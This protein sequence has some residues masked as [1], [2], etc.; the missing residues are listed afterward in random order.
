MRKPKILFYGNCQIGAISKIFDTHPILKEKFTVLNAGDYN[1]V[2]QDPYPAVANFLLNTEGKNDPR[3]IEKIF[4]D[5]DIVVFQALNNNRV[6]EYCLTKNIIPDFDGLS[7]CIPSFWYGGY[8]GA[9]Y[10][11]PMLDLFYYFNKLGLSN[12]EALNSL[13]NEPILITEKLFVY[14]HDFSIEGLKSRS[15]EQAGN[16]NF[17][18]ILDWLQNTYKNRLLCYNHSHPTPV[19]FNFIVNKILNKIDPS[20]EDMNLSKFN[21]VHAGPDGYFLP[22][23]FRFF[24]DLFPD[25]E[26]LSKLEISIYD[27]WR[28]YNSQQ[29]EIFVNEGMKYVKENQV[30]DGHRLTQ[31]VKS[32][33]GVK[34][35]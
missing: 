5:A 8:F 9:P 13:L 28:S 29:T 25:L 11:F 27:R 18:P 19:F 23:K 30:L 21:F 12:K 15:K 24:N 20:I 6:P 34:N 10:K 7:I 26:P 17:I 16:Y 33:L 2:N 35:K 14:Y 31:E 3:N 22:T 1:L 32:I 4:S